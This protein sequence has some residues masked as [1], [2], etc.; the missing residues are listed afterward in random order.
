MQHSGVA[1]READWD[2]LAKTTRPRLID[3][4]MPEAGEP[5]DRSTGKSRAIGVVRVVWGRPPAIRVLRCIP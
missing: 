3:A 2:S 5:A 4:L 1:A